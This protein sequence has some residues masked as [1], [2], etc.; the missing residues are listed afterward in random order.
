[1]NVEVCKDSATWDRYVEAAPNASNYHRWVW[2][3]VIEETFGHQSHYLWAVENG[4]VQGVLPLVSIRS[5][6][7]GRFLVSVP[8]FTYGG[9]LASTPEAEQQLLAAATELATGLGA[10]HIELRQGEKSNTNWI[11][12]T[13]KVTMQV[14][15]PDKPALLWDR[16]SAKLRKR[17]RYASRNGLYSQWDGAEA[18][19]QFYPVFA[20][21]MR[22]LG[23]P[24]YPRRWF[25]NISRK[26]P[27]EIRVLTLLEEGKPVAAA[28]LTIFRDTLEL[29]WAAS[30]PDSRRKFS[31]LLLYWTLLEWAI[32]AGFR[33]VDLGR[34]TPGSGNHEFKS[35]WRCNEKPLHWYYWLSPR[36]TVPQTRPDNPRFRLP[37]LIWKH[38][39]LFLANGLGPRIVRS[40]P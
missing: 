33:R 31:P 38:L 30:L 11:D 10:R 2:K 18:I 40:L 7:F 13:P 9:V 25:E 22:N 27:A 6:L 19:E 12:L 28:F 17:I 23:T 39:P 8:F 20:T 3:E 35:R 37:I 16:L 32:Q 36:A 24:A 5:L 21:N 1:M 4:L 29:P 34:C 14:P 26:L 15:L